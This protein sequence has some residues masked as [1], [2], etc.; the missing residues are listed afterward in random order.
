VRSPHLGGSGSDG[1]DRR[2]GG[3]AERA[4][5]WLPGFGFKV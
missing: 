5:G 3:S 4:R 1:G 2:G